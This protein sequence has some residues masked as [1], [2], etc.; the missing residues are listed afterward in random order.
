MF[1]LYLNENFK[2]II[3]KKNILFILIDVSFSFNV[4]SGKGL[5]GLL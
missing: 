3:M 2:N 4:F 1:L 5:L